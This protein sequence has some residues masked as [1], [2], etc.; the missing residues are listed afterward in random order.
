MIR[1]FYKGSDDAVVDD[2]GS[3][4]GDDEGEGRLEIGV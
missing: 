4:S 1:P 3:G 2:G